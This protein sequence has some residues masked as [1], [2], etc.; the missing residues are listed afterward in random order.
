MIPVHHQ[1]QALGPTVGGSR[2][3][4]DHHLMVAGSLEFLHRA[5]TS[6]VRMKGE[7]EAVESK[8]MRKERGWGFG[9]DLLFLNSLAPDGNQGWKI[10]VIRR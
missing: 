7:K 4:A 5:R 1:G 3:T 2:T 8:E 6:R 10:E 9:S